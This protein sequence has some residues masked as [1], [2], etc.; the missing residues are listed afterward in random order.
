MVEAVFPACFPG[1]VSQG[2][3]GLEPL[4]PIPM[5]FLAPAVR[6]LLVM[7]QVHVDIWRIPS[8]DEQSAGASNGKPQ[9]PRLKLRLQPKLDKGGHIA[10]AALSP[11]G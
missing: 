7:H 4:P 10:C 8:R 1:G 11:N 6:L 9:A 2:P 5:A 3:R